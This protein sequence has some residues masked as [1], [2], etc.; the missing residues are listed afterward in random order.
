M[1]P[2]RYTVDY[3][4]C[5]PVPCLLHVVRRLIA[6]LLLIG[7]PFLASCSGSST[8]N[9]GVGTDPAGTVGMVDSTA[10]ITIIKSGDE[11]RI[12]DNRSTGNR[13]IPGGSV[14]VYSGDDIRI[15][16]KS[17]SNIYIIFIDAIDH[18]KEFPGPFSYN[19]KWPWGDKV[20]PSIRIGAGSVD[21]PKCV[22]YEAVG[23]K[24]KEQG[25]DYVVLV[26]K[27]GKLAKPEP[28]GEPEVEPEGYPEDGPIIIQT[29]RP[30]IIVKG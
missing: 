11:Y 16:N 17:D 28:E 8:T 1:L 10:I 6:G 18:K 22:E 15:C 29:L 2:A 27:S 4:I 30:K 13:R 20:I 19:S 24:D 25:Y 21:A 7:V 9:Q 14:D 12:T 23:I 26:Q 3:R 5:Q